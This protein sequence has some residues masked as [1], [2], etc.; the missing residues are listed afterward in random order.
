[1][2]TVLMLNGEII[3]IEDLVL[4]AGEC[5]DRGLELN[6]CGTGIADWMVCMTKDTNLDELTKGEELEYFFAIAHGN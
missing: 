2:A 5:A 1:M 6:V 3:V 4:F